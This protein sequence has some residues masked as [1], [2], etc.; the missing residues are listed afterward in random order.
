MMEMSRAELVRLTSAW[1][2]DRFEDGRP[3]VPEDTLG[4][5]AALTAEHAWHVLDENGYPYQYVGGWRSTQD[6]P[7]V[8]RA[9]TSQ[10]LPIRP[11]LNDAVDAAGRDRGFAAGS[12]QNTWVVDSL[13]AGDVMVADIFGKVSEGT[14]I[15]DNLGSAVAVRTQAG[16]VIDGGVRDLTGLSSLTNAN[17]YYRDTDPTPIRNVTLAGVNI[18]VRIGL[19]TVLPGDVVF[20]TRGGVTFIPPHLAEEIVRQ[21]E[22]IRDRDHFAKQRIAEGRYSSGEI[23]VPAWPEPIEED[24]RA[25]SLARSTQ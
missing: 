3:R 2:G 9:V 16:A 1:T 25:W 21:G 23:D 17:F 8:G 19:T 4:R 11:D 6:R 20:G 18:P 7:L 12:Q 10:Y 14:V 24:F 22:L 15:G 13:V 5:L